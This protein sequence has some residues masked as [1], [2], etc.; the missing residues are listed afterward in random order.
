MLPIWEMAEC[1]SLFTVLTVYH[2][3]GIHFTMCKFKN[4]S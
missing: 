1:T 2:R 3:V 4:F